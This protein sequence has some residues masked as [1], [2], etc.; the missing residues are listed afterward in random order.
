M[1][2]VDST[3]EG[4]RFMSRKER[5]WDQFGQQVTGTF[6]RATGYTYDSEKV[7]HTG[8]RMPVVEHVP[9]DVGAAVKWL[10]NRR[11]DQWRE[12]KVVQPEV[13]FQQTFLKFL[14]KMDE[15]IKLERAKRAKLIEHERTKVD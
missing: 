9:P 1:K 13:S 12:T 3:H 6:R 7:F 15:E 4:A 5:S 10:Q 14:D 11:P 8:K 2:A